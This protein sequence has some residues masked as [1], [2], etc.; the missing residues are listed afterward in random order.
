MYNLVKRALPLLV[1]IFFIVVIFGSFSVHEVEA[2]SLGSVKDTITTSRPSAASPINAAAP[3]GSGTIT[4]H[5]NGS[6]YLASD[7][8]TIIRT[9]GGI[10]TNMTYVASATF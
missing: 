7:S 4:I 6:R 2:A 3:A 8:A 9:A 10:A 1:S 5:N